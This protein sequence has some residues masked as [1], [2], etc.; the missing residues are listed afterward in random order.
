MASSRKRRQSEP[1]E[2][3]AA[4]LARHVPRGARLTLALSGGVDSIVALDILAGLAPA[5]PFALE[6]LHVNHGLS[7]NAGGWGRFARAAA[8]RYG[9]RCTVRTADLA[10]HRR[11]GVEGAARAARYAAFAR[12]RADFVVLAQHQDDQAET[13]LLQLLRGA[14]LA[15][16]SGMAPARAGGDERAPALLRPLLGVSRAEIERYARRR[17]LEW[18]EDESNADERF[19]RNFLRRR[20]MPLLAELNPAAG[21]NLARSAAHLAEGQALARS[22]AE[23]DARGTLRDGRLSVAVLAALPRGR[24]KNLLRWAIAAARVAP[25]DASRLDEMLRQLVAARTDAA[26]KI[27]LDGAEVRRYRDSVWIVPLQPPP[28]PG[29]RARWDGRSAL[30]LPELR[31]TLRF[32]ATIGR[33]MKA[34]ALAAGM[35]EV[36]LRGGGEQFQPDPGRP[37][38]LLKTLLQEIGLPPWERERLPLVYCGEK[39]VAVPG[40]GIAADVAAAPRERGWALTWTPLVDKLPKAPKAMIK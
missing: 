16:L 9:L 21:A 8:R 6:C 35:V 10:P 2:R 38:R 3:V 39:L 30:R 40:I 32:K 12:A 7:P 37:R 18:V 27:A 5:H 17:G 33:G 25:P 19:A 14:G 13:V 11:L 31:G 22:L 1:R 23:I 15:G 36:R 29:F 24:A 34:S 20:V 4:E 26:V 28:P